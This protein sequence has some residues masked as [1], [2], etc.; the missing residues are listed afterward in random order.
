[1][2]NDVPAGFKQATDMGGYNATIQPFY[3]SRENDEFC[4]EFELQTQHSPAHCPRQWPVQVK[5]E[6]SSQ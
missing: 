4:M 3:Y 1:M 5:M 2:V 6:I